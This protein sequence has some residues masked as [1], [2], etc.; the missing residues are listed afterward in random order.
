MYRYRTTSR[1][2]RCLFVRIPGTFSKFYMNTCSEHASCNS[3]IFPVISNIS[4]HFLRLFGN[5]ASALVVSGAVLITLHVHFQISIIAASRE[6]SSYTNLNEITWV[7]MRSQSWFFFISWLM[8]FG[9]CIEYRSAESIGICI[10]L[11]LRIVLL[12]LMFCCLLELGKKH[13]I[14]LLRAIAS[15]L[16]IN[17]KWSPLA[18]LHL[19][20]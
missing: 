13:E 19:R 17:S 6:A 18:A 15:T 2:L 4:N 16:L 14:I 12:I 1:S 8:I 11:Y 5:A 3:S 20:Q 10:V 9:I 7:Y